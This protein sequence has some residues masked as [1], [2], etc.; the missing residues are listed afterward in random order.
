MIFFTLNLFNCGSLSSQLFKFIW[1]EPC[2][3]VRAI[4]FFTGLPTTSILFAWRQGSL[5]S[6]PPKEAR[7]LT[8]ANGFS[9]RDKRFKFSKLRELEPGRWR[10]KVIQIM[11]HL[12]GF[13]NANFTCLGTWSSP[14][15]FSGPKYSEEDIM[16]DCTSHFPMHDLSSLCILLLAQICTCTNNRFG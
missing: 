5:S 13:L 12:T 3:D 7:R 8:S 6:A 10:R 2:E 16:R 15:N 9:S 1:S 4:S 11:R 14:T